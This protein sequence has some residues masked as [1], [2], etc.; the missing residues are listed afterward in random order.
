MIICIINFIL[1]CFG[2][3]CNRLHTYYLK[4]LIISHS[5]TLTI[6]PL[7]QLA[8]IK[9]REVLKSCFIDK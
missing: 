6:V 2:L 8:D 7:I 3:F 1:L 9:L 4:S 5:Y